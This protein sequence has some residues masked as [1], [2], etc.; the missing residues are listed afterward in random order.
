M[1]LKSGRSHEV[2]SQNIKEM[3][4]SGHPHRQAIA[5]ALSNARKSYK[6]MAKGG[7]AESE[8]GDATPEP[9]SHA[10]GSEEPFSEHIEGE[11]HPDA[12]HLE[13]MSPD[14]TEYRPDSDRNDNRN[15]RGEQVQASFASRDNVENPPE[16]KKERSLAQ[17]IQDLSDEEDIEYFAEGGLVQPE[18][19]DEELGNKP[20]AD[21]ELSWINDGTEQPMSSMP[22]KPA[23]LEHKIEGAPKHAMGMSEPLMNVI[24]DRKKKRRYK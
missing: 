12:P 20:M 1:P 18:Y 4:K 24:M 22:K 8:D 5:A 23:V 10:A 6:K 13:S 21:G 9:Q 2:I 7:L 19:E 17:A 3:I 11:M 15:S 14:E 16:Q